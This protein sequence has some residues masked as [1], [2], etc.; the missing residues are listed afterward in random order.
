[1]FQAK[2]E[3]PFFSANHELDSLV[4]LFSSV[5]TLMSRSE[6]QYILLSEHD[7]SFYLVF[8][9]FVTHAFMPLVFAC[10]CSAWGALHSERNLRTTR[11]RRQ[12]PM[13]ERCS[14]VH[15]PGGKINYFPHVEDFA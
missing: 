7:P 3:K 4:S 8:L 10:A 11:G 2:A 12:F 9:R 13:S 6:A 15:A 14:C 1:L 5:N